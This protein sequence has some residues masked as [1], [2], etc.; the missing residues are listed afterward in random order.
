MASSGNLLADRRYAYAEAALVE[1]DH[2]AAIDLARQTLELI[3]GYAPA[4]FVLG[5]AHE[6]RF[7]ALESGPDASG[8]YRDAIAAYET[9]RALDPEDRL[10]AGLRLA[11]ASVGD[12]LAAM[13]P[14]Y[15][16]QLFDD[17]AIRFDRQLRQSLR[18]R[19]P[20]L[21][22]DAVRRACS[23]RLRPFAFARALDLGCG[24]GLVAE[25]F[26][27]EC[28]HLAGIDLSAEMVK[29][30]QAKRLYDDL[31]TG[32]LIPWLGAQPVAA[33]DLVLAAD[34]FVYMADLTP[35]F[36]TTARA[37]RPGGLFGFTVQAHS[38]GGV[39][40]GEDHRYAHAEGYLRALAEAAG[41]AVVMCEAVSTRQDRG[42][43]VAGL[44][45]VL[46]R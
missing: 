15:V 16:T 36:A 2:Q 6:A 12:P 25:V 39:V 35:V 45:L 31:A 40:L 32:D 29:R 21:L 26:R 22:H 7:R 20:E 23:L 41:L 24:T 8:E 1:G 30:A 28:R 19:G 37:L 33:A 18:Y 42:E 13:S 5:Q 14:A 4:W 38:D 9:A 17:Y 10:G 43:P 46:D 11:L 34:V 3:P 27:A 44:L